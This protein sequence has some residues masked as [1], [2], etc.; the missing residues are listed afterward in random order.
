MV[1][2][3]LIEYVNREINNTLRLKFILLQLRCY[4][5]DIKIKAM[6]QIFK[7]YTC[8][9]T[10]TSTGYEKEYNDPVFGP[11]KKTVSTCPNCMEEAIVYKKPSPKKTNTTEGCNAG[12]A[13]CGGHCEF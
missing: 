1:W 8:D 5:F 12:A 9:I 6:E 13:C 3:G 2:E 10:F 7:C 11:C 4:L